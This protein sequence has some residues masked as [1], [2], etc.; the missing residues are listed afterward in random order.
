V[1]R[2]GGHHRLLVVEDSPADLRLLR[3]A[4]REHGLD[5]VIDDVA[6]GELALRHLR[7][8]G[9]RP[10]LILLDLNLPRLH[11]RE[12]LEA[13]K[14]DPRLRSIPV[15]V[16]STSAS[17]RDVADCYAR[18]ASAYLVK[19]MGLDELGDL[20]RAIDAFWLRR[21]LLPG[22]GAGP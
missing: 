18:H 4:V 14:A 10:D 8:D 3:E 19:P 17:P 9:P 2:A 5:V 1:S 21:A 12:V 15:L 22:A 16:L 11:G 13:I 6:D 20:V 7:G